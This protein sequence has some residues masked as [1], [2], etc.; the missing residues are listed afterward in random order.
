MQILATAATVRKHN[1]P[2]FTQTK[3]NQ[4]KKT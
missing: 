2:E 1:L 3:P 4:F